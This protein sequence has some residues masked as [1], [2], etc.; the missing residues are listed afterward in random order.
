MFLYRPA[1]SESTYWLVGPQNQLHP[2]LQNPALRETFTALNTSCLT[3]A[4]LQ[5]LFP[6]TCLAPAHTEWGSVCVFTCE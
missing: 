6:Y 4:L 2:H 1:E 5:V 3:T